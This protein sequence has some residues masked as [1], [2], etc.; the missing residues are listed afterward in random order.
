MR[1]VEDADALRLVG[2]EAHNLDV[3]DY[4]YRVGQVRIPRWMARAA[5]RPGRTLVNPPWRRDRR[6]IHDEIIEQIDRVG[7][8]WSMIC[9]PVG[10]GGHPDHHV[11]REV[12]LRL[13]RERRI[14]TRLYADVPYACVNGWPTWT[15]QPSPTDDDG[16]IEF[17]WS[18]TAYKTPCDVLPPWRDARVIRLDRDATEA[19][20]RA[21]SMYATQFDD[22]NRYFKGRMEHP[23]T[24]GT[25]AFW[26]VPSS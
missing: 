6:G 23:E 12:A 8:M 21:V 18:R 24:W 20:R 14:P 4:P 16:A 25:E 1:R 10:I 7:S 5:G 3:L 15:N 11:V 13:A 17:E 9:A 19:K 2:R 26:S 22:L